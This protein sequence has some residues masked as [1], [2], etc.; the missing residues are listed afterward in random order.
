MPEQPNCLVCERT[1][2]Q[3]PLIVLRYQGGYLYICAQHL[4]VLIHKPEEL[5]T[6]LPAAASFASYNIDEPANE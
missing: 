3:T 4:P 5:A 6:Y 2:E 1:E